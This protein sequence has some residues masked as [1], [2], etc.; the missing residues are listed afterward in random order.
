[1]DMLLAET[2]PQL[3]GLEADTYW[4]ERGGRN[5]REF[6]LQHEAR[7]GMIHAKEFCRDGRDVPAGQGDVDWKTIIPL[8]RSRGWP[9]VV[10]YEAENALAA[11]AASAVYLRGL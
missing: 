2:D 7:I 5:S 8:A 9:I 1:M 4:V 11:V 10:E 6:I 3:V